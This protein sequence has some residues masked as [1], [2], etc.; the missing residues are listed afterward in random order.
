MI[1]VNGN[2]N[3][4]SK[5]AIYLI[6][7]S[8]Y[9]MLLYLYLSSIMPLVTGVTYE[10]Y[11]YY[12][13]YFYSG[14]YFIYTQIKCFKHLFEFRFIKL[15]AGNRWGKTKYRGGTCHLCPSVA[16]QTQ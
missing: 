9:N 7:P 14:L 13:L 10:Y 2:C 1:H 5:I 3:M 4:I 16:L 8:L 15:K 6:N 12:V 11:K